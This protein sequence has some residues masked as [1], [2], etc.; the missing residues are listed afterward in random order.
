MTIFTTPSR[1]DMTMDRMGLQ[2]AQMLDASVDTLPAD[3]SERL[4]A[5]RTQ[6]LAA[7]KPET[8]LQTASAMGHALALGNG[9]EESPKFWRY[10]GSVLPVAALLVGLMALQVSNHEQK[11]RE[12]AE[13]DSAL[14]VDDLPPAAYTDPGF[15]Q[16]LRHTPAAS[17]QD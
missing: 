14:L 15:M 5:A 2:L 10:L 4:R 6:A 13:I 3:I 11:V 8:A 1:H 12:L 7:R 16:F 17:A 9:T